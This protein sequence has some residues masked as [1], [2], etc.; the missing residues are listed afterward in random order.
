MG[1]CREACKLVESGGEAAAKL[2]SGW[3]GGGDGKVAAAI[4]REWRE[5][6]LISVR[7]QNGMHGLD[8]N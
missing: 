5:W 1:W 3:N 8:R 7:V 6:W 4:G 2:G